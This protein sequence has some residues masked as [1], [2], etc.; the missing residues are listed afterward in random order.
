MDRIETPSYRDTDTSDRLGELWADIPGLDGLYQISNFGR[1]M[2]KERI[3]NDV[4]GR[5]RTISQK[6]ILPQINRDRNMLMKDW[7]LRLQVIVHV[8]KIAY[9]FQIN[10]LV[11][12]CFVQEFN[13]E[14]KFWVVRAKS[15]DGLD[16]F[17]ENLELVTYGV[18]NQKSYDAGRQ[19]S[20]FQ[21]SKFRLIEANLAA[22]AATSIAVSRYDDKGCLIDTFN[23]I[24]DAAK[25]LGISVSGIIAASKNSARKS[26]GYYWRKG[27]ASKINW[28]E[29]SEA[30]HKRKRSFR[31]KRGKKVTQ[32]DLLGN[33]I[34]VFATKSEAARKAGVSHRYISMNIQGIVDS[35][36]GYIWREG[37]HLAG[38]R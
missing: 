30:I 28:K 23:S 8:D 20:P 34:A 15:G 26:G 7:S 2:R 14:D 1:V 3:I 36:G 10:R 31:E 37:D 27:S 17:P 12:Y 33:P 13:L 18:K 4:L 22:K 25:H 9:H 38:N 5:P 35:A 21:V 32:F 19:L 16:V 24:S 29:V 6:V 11:Y